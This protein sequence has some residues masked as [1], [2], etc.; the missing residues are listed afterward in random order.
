[1]KDINDRQITVYSTHVDEFGKAVERTP[2]TH[3]YSYDDFVTWRGGKNEDANATVYTDRLLQW[4]YKKYNKLSKKHFNN[5]AQIWYD[6]EPS[7]IEAFM[8][9]W[10]GDKN[11]KLI[12]VMQSCNQSS[13]FPLWRFHYH[14]T[15]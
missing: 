7:K 8:R 2:Y 15:K 11:L 10:T 14:T 3:P 9:D 1:M 6:R 5:E 13:G 4:D 12:L